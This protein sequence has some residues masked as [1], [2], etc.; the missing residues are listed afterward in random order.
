MQILIADDDVELCSL[1]SEYL[2]QEDMQVD[3]VHDGQSAINKL[4][5]SSYDLLILDVMMPIMNGINTLAELRKTNPTPIIMLTAKGD[6]IDRI[7]G[8]EMGAD[9]YVAKPCDP[10]ELV[11]RI[12]AVTRRTKNN[13]RLLQ[14]DKIKVDD[15]VVNK[16]NRQVLLSG[17]S[18]ALTSTEFDF[19]IQLLEN[20]GALVSR[21]DLSQKVLGKKI[22]PHDRS[23]D[24][25][26]SNIRK[27]LGPNSS[28]LERIKTLR[29]NGY[30]YLTEQ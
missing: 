12:R 14:S 19:L 28:N 9:D 6:K 21:E 8:L 30:Q 10:R 27:K 2:S 24:M 17:N 20:P 3:Q 7:V 16:K 4:S 29:G 11:A 1:L 18:I 5:N 23:I 15:L 13:G 22:Q 26:I 25:H